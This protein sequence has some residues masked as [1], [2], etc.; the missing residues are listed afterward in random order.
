MRRVVFTFHPRS[1]ATAMTLPQTSRECSTRRL[2]RNDNINPLIIPKDQHSRHVM[3]TTSSCSV[4]CKQLYC[5][6]VFNFR[7]CQAL[8]LMGDK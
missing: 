3:A 1:T 8:T 5:V 4:I 7:E 2:N 6:V